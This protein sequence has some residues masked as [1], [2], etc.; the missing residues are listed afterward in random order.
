VHDHP[1][2]SFPPTPRLGGRGET[3]A[4]RRPQT[5]C[6]PNG[7]ACASGEMTCGTAAEPAVVRAFSLAM[8][9]TAAAIVAAYDSC[10]RG[11][12]PRPRRAASVLYLI[13]FLRRRKLAALRRSELRIHTVA[14]TVGVF[15]SHCSVSVLFSEEA[16]LGVVHL[17]CCV[18]EASS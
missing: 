6:A 5:N 8:A 9:S 13:P 4:R 11:A 17:L 16:L 18:V 10:S 1:R 3:A 7:S 15:Q 2:P 12:R 14:V